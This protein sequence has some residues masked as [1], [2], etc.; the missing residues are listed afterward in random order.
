MATPEGCF[1]GDKLVVMSQVSSGTQLQII[2]IGD[3][4]NPVVNR[5]LE[6]ENIAD[7]RLI[8]SDV[9]LALNTIW[10]CRNPFGKSFKT[11]AMICLR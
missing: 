10:T 11:T 6:V 7:A 5:R 9:Y 4:A 1:K 3:R 8:D 2:D